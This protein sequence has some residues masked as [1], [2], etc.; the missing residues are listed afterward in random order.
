[1][2]MVMAIEDAFIAP[3]YFSKLFDIEGI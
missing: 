1:M 3:D 2:I